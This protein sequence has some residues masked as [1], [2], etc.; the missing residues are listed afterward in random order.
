MQPSPLPISTTEEFK[1]AL[2]SLRDKNIP[3]AHRAMLEAQCLGKRTSL[4]ISSH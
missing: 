3:E 1:R 4:T 2:L